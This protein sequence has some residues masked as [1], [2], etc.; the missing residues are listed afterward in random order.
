M[1]ILL[2]ECLNWRLK[3]EFESHEVSAVQELGWSGVVNGELL[4]LASESSFEVLI[5][6]DKNL[7][8]QQNIKKYQ[9]II[10]VLQAR[11]NKME[12]LRP[13]IP[14]VLRKLPM[15]KHGETYEIG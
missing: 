10:V 14:I 8:F 5:T 9:L 1:K 4:R 12:Y 7:E 2:D 13:L 3:R 6:I 15:M 11:L